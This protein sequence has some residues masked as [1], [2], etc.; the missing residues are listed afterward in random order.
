MHSAHESHPA[1]QHR[2]FAKLRAGGT[3]KR[4]FRADSLPVGALPWGPAHPTIVNASDAAV[5]CSLPFAA[6][7]VSE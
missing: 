3:P 6:V 4:P 1:A 7:I 5:E 2:P